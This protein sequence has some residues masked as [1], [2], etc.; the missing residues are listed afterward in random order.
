VS[1][2]IVRLEREGRIAFVTLNRP[3][4]LNAM[5]LGMQQEL[6]AAWTEVRADDAIRVAVL[7]GEGRAFCSG[8]DLSGPPQGTTPAH[9]TVAQDRQGL[10]D[11][12]LTTG[13]TAWELPKPVISQVHGYCLGIGNI[14][15]T[16]TDVIIAAEDAKIGWPTLPLG[17]GLISPIW[18]WFVG[19]YRAKELSMTVGSLL[20]GSEAISLGWGNRAVPESQLADVTYEV[21]REFAKLPSDLLAVKKAAINKQ[22]EAKGF[23]NAVMM[24]AEMDAIA[25]TSEAVGHIARMR[26]ELGNRGTRDWWNSGDGI[27]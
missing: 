13:F 12:I 17:G 19:P 16:L 6:R 22:M 9:R 8:A 5:N 14:V 11:G 24:G 23:K 4:K 7:R 27:P 10:I 18:S 15:A 1:D 25:H 3:E 26:A 2:G 20:S 21:A